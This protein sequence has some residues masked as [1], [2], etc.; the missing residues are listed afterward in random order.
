M[1][2][3]DFALNER[4][5]YLIQVYGLHASQSVLLPPV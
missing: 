1:S 4:G 2:A 5:V 3:G